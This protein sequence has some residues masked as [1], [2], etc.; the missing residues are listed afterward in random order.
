MRI[1]TAGDSVRNR[2]NT[3]SSSGSPSIRVDA[4]ESGI[5][6]RGLY[7]FNQAFRQLRFDFHRDRQADTVQRERSVRRAPAGSGRRFWGG[8]ELLV[9][10]A[11]IFK[12]DYPANGT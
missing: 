10:K 6:L 9:C 3:L 1:F 2:Y 11:P 4:P 8:D 5:L 7:T 12:A